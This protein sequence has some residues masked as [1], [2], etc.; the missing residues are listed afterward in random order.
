MNN[1]KIK[2]L[3]LGATGMLGNDVFYLL[4]QSDQLEVFGTIR[5]SSNV[6]FPPSLADNLLVDVDVIG[7]DNELIRVLGVVRP[8]IVINCIGVVKQLK[9]CSDPLW[10]IP[11]NSLLPHRLAK[12]C[13][14]I[15]AR[16]IHISTDCI[17]SGNAGMYIETDVSDANDLYGRTKFIGEVDYPNAITLRTSI[18]GHEPNGRNRSLVDWFISQSRPVGGYTNAIFSGLPCVELASII[19]DF[20]IPSPHLNGVYHVASAPIS[21]FELLKMISKVYNLT[22]PIYPDHSVSIN[23]SLDST[24]FSTATGY[25]YKSWLSLIT[26]MHNFSLTKGI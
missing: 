17:F 22:I 18:I 9:E 7:D 15:N 20:V 6:V 10:V 3:V 14:Q 4:S 16:L 2:V 26:Y 13:A 8:N 24:K 21:K 25:K 11:I 1:S 23:R 19:R 5:S 12:F